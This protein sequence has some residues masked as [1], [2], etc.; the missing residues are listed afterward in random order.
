MPNKEI[1]SGYGTEPE[2]P[3]AL[4]PR[5]FP[6]TREAHLKRQEEDKTMM[7]CALQNEI[8]QNKCDVWAPFLSQ[9]VTLRD[10]WQ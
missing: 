4:A 8:K 6:M 3:T 7:L 2:M 9:T 1:K 5:A 10:T